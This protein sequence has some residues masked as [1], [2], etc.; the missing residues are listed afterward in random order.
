MSHSNILT[1]SGS[2]G[3]MSLVVGKVVRP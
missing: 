3:G 1:L 2:S